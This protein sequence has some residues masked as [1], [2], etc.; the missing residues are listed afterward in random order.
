MKVRYDLP[1]ND[2]AEDVIYT[3]MS[4]KQ[5]LIK[6][7]AIIDVPGTPIKSLEIELSRE[8]NPDELISLGAFLGTCD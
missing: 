3:L 7:V 1:D 8:L 2:C 4:Y 5:E 6:D